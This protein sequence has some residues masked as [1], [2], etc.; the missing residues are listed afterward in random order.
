VS[1]IVYSSRF[2]FHHK[3]KLLLGLIQKIAAIDRYLT[4]SNA[5]R[6]FTAGRRQAKAATRPKSCL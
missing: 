6:Y 3:L 4:M 2:R 5:D 1:V